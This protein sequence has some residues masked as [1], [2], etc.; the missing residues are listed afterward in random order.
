MKEEMIQMQ[1]VL[2]MRN[3]LLLLIYIFVCRL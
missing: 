2:I 1:M 3:N